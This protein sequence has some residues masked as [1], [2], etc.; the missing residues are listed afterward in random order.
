MNP[1]SLN[2]PS[3]LLAL[4]LGV[5]SLV[6]AAN[7]LTAMQNTGSFGGGSSGGGTN[8][9]WIVDLLTSGVCAA[10]VALLLM[11]PHLYVFV[12]VVGWA[13]LAFLANYI[14]RHTPGFDVLATV[15]MTLYFVTLVI[16]GVLVVFEGRDWLEV[17]MARRRTAPPPQQ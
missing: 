15:R 9:G 1:R 17:S 4:L 8:A 13:L 6:D 11:R 12:A 3:Y 14:M 10:L 7:A 2:K 5:I 16:G